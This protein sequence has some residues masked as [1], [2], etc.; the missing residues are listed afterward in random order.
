MLTTQLAAVLTRGFPDN[1]LCDSQGRSQLTTSINET[2]NR[3]W[4]RTGRCRWLVKF[5]SI[6]TS[7]LP[8]CRRGRGYRRFEQAAKVFVPSIVLGELYYGANNSGG[9]RHR[10][11]RNR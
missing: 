7:S 11:L 8:Y 3:V 6:L 1:H 9:V 4:V 10:I 2:G 5:F